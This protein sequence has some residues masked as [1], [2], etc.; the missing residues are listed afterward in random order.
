[1]SPALSASSIRGRTPMPAT[2]RSASSVPPLLS[3]TCLPSMALA[4]SSRWKTTPCSSWSER[5]KSPICG[6]RMRS[7]GRLSGATTW[8]SISRARRAAATS[9]P[10]KLAPSTTARRAV[11]ACSMMA[12]QS[13]S[14]RSVRTCG[15]VGARDRQADWLGAGREQQPVIRNLARHRRARPRANARRCRRHS[16]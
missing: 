9:S 4:V 3:F 8:T 11:L 2:T 1:M 16:P 14:E 12:R 15:M 13:A 5:T 7:I 6:P 10:I